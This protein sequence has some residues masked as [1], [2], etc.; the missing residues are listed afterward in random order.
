LI[1]HDDFKLYVLKRKLV[2][3]E[4][5]QFDRASIGHVRATHL[6]PRRFAG[7]LRMTGRHF[8]IE[9]K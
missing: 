5:E 3:N 6:N 9:Q 4:T 8:A 7:E 2:M 1:S